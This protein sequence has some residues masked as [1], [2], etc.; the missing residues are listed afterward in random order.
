MRY[1]NQCIIID[2]GNDLTIID[3]FEVNFG[4]R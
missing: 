3:K 2:N 1:L 4:K